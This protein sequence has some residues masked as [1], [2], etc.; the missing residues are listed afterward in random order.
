M[1]NIPSHFSVRTGREF[2]GSCV[3][4][5]MQSQSVLFKIVYW[6]FIVIS[7]FLFRPTLFSFNAWVS[8]QGLLERFS[9]YC[10]K[11]IIMIALYW[12]L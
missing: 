11:Q 7:H 5:S 3:I 2:R 1:T 8:V 10:P 6:L 9:K 4:K 12:E